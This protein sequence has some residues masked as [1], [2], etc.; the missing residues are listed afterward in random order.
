MGGDDIQYRIFVLEV[1]E[2]R[3]MKIMK[4]ITTP[5]VMASYYTRDRPDVVIGATILRDTIFGKTQRIWILLGALSTQGDI[6][7]RKGQL[8]T[9]RMKI[10]TI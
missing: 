6:E 9:G 7:Y 1:G 10:A 3:G 2:E 5:P 4:I 8:N